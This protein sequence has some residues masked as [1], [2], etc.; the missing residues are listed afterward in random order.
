MLDEFWN[1]CLYT[2]FCFILRLLFIN[3]VKVLMN[4]SYTLK[5]QI[6]GEGGITGEAGKFQSK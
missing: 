1:V 2:G 3:A 4:K 6:E 5:F